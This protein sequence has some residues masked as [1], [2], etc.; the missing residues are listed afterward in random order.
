MMRVATS[1]SLTDIGDSLLPQTLHSILS[2]SIVKEIMPRAGGNHQ[3]GRNSIT[4]A[5]LTHLHHHHGEILLVQSL[6]R[7]IQPPASA[8]GQLRRQHLR[9]E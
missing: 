1:L 8:A 4:T 5:L 9:G 2:L 7:S 6:H 3:T